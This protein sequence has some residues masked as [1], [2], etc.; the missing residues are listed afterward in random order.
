VTILKNE[1]IWTQLW[2]QKQQKVWGDRCE[3]ASALSGGHQIYAAKQIG[4]WTEF[5][6]VARKEFGGIIGTV[7]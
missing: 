5:L 2:F 3:R 7:S 1:M 6:D 4:M